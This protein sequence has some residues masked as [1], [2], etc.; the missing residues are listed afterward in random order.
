MSFSAWA[1]MVSPIGAVDVEVVPIAPVGTLD[2]DE[3]AEVEV[4]PSTE[5]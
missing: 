1:L 2:D 3:V 5:G 4:V